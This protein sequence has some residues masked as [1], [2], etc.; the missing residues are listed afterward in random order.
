MFNFIDR[1]WSIRY[2]RLIN[3][4]AKTYPKCWALIYQ[5]DVRMRSEKVD[6]ILDDLETEHA[7]AQKRNWDSDFDP[8][9]P[10]NAVWRRIVEGKREELWW[11]RNVE[12]PAMFITND[13]AKEGDYIEGD[14]LPAPP[15]SSRSPL[16]IELGAA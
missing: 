3:T 4:L 10:W 12:K 7:I 15:S 8:K 1:T 11:F 14:F 6:D 5:A 13:V 16:S 2:Q 9:R